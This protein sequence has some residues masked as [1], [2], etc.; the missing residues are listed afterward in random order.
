MTDAGNV[1]ANASENDPEHH[2]VRSTL[3]SFLTARRPKKVAK[4]NLH[5]D[6]PQRPKLLADLTGKNAKCSIVDWHR[7]GGS[8][9]LPYPPAPHGHLR[10]RAAEDLDE[11]TRVISS[12]PQRSGEMDKDERVNAVYWHAVLRYVNRQALTNTSLRERFKIEAHN[13][14]AV[15]WLI[16]EAVEAG[17]IIPYDP[18][19]AAKLMK[20]LP[21][22]TARLERG[23][24][25]EGY[26]MGRAAM[27]DRRPSKTPN[28]TLD[29]G[30]RHLPGT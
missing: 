13:S 8:D 16:R 26:L 21:F 27:A 15:S 4:L 3:L 10:R 1:R 2:A 14:A 17:R 30:L 20:Y 24:V 18:E 11:S 29:H 28:L 9:D 22:W 25:L 7:N 12:S 5:P 23:R 6:S 19:A